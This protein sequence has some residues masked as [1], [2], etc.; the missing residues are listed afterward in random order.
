MFEGLENVLAFNKKFI[1]K[2]WLSHF[3]KEKPFFKR[4]T[5]KINVS[6]RFFEKFG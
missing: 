5:Q 1:P 6:K 4:D 2:N 3:Q